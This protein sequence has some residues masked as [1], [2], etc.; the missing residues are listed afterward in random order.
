MTEDVRGL[1]ESKFMAG[2]VVGRALLLLC[3]CVDELHV[4][5]RAL[6]GDRDEK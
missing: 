4:R 6:E 2:S 1:I 3:G 5:I